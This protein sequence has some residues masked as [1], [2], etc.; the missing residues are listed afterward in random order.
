MLL[1]VAAAPVIGVPTALLFVRLCGEKDACA[2]A[3]EVAMPAG[4]P[5]CTVPLIVG[6]LLA[7]AIQSP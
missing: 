6:L 5:R 1:L 3:L 2:V 7:P 4:E